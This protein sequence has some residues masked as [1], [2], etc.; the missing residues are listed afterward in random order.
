MDFVSKLKQKHHQGNNNNNLFELLP[1]DVILIIFNKIQDVKT[2]ITCFSFNKHLASLILQTD[3][4]SLSLILPHSSNDNDT[5]ANFVKTDKSG[6]NYLATKL[7]HNCY[8]PAAA[9]ATVK[10]KKEASFSDDTPCRRL[11]LFSQISQLRVEIH[12]DVTN[13]NGITRSNDDEIF[14]WKARFS[15]RLKS[16]TLLCCSKKLRQYVGGGDWW[17]KSGAITQFKEREYRMSSSF[18]AAYARYRLAREMATQF[19]TLKKVKV[20]DAKREGI[21]TMTE[22]EIRDMKDSWKEEEE[23]GEDQEEEETTTYLL[24]M[25]YVPL[26]ELPVAK[27]MWKDAMFIVIRPMDI[28]S[29]MV[30]YGF[31]CDAKEQKMF[32]EVIREIM[33]SGKA[34]RRAWRWSCSTQL[35][36]PN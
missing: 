1:D 30:D 26:L 23:G 15:G 20:T 8:V 27:C 14:K 13:N 9:A 34:D 3:V 19:A 6:V 29:R 28:H 12:S 4:V 22:D 16:W 18:K 24:Q 5:K 32:T 17:P 36:H 33:K 11:R 35:H 2:L 25:W 21:L 10:N 31:D 7:L